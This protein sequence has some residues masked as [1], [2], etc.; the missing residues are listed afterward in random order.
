MYW[1]EK[2]CRKNTLPVFEGYFACCYSIIVHEE[3]EISLDII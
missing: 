2:Y 3:M 1:I